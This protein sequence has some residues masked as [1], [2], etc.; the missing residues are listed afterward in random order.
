MFPQFSAYMY[1]LCVSIGCTDALRTLSISND[2]T[3]CD[4]FLPQ[5]AQS[6]LMKALED[7]NIYPSE[8]V[9]KPVEAIH[10]KNMH[11]YVCVH[12]V[13]MY[14]GTYM[15]MFWVL[16]SYQCCVHILFTCL[17][18]LNYTSPTSCLTCYICLHSP[19]S[20]LVFFHYTCTCV[21]CLSVL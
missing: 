9:N 19:C 16:S 15:Y 14:V 1:I 11:V 2:C 4:R 12:Y 3:F 5:L 17:M 7:A 20:M 18:F 13:C 8:N 21:I 6:A 10:C